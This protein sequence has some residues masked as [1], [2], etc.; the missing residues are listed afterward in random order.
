MYFEWISVCKSRAF[1][2]SRPLI[3][4]LG[5]DLPPSDEVG[6]ESPLSRRRVCHSGGPCTQGG[7]WNRQ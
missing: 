3:L 5:E 2:V 1:N 6:H 4:V 7:L